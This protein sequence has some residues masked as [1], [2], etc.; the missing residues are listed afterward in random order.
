[1]ETAERVLRQAAAGEIEL[2]VPAMVIAEIIWTL[3]TSVFNLSKQ[4]AS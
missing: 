2:I 1:V 3:E 4:E